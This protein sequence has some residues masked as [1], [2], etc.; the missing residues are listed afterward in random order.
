[1]DNPCTAYIGRD[2]DRK[3]HSC[4]LEKN[5]NPKKHKCSC[6]REWYRNTL[7]SECRKA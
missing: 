1:M 7:N 5:H 3:I 4:I 6:N 2:S